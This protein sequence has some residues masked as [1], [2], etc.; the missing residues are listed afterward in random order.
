[1]E[2][3]V[4]LMLHDECSGFFYPS[5]IPNMNCCYL[6]SHRPSDDSDNEI[7]FLFPFPLFT[8]FQN[9]QHMFTK[10]LQILDSL[11]NKH[12]GSNKLTFIL[13]LDRRGFDCSSFMVLFMVSSGWHSLLMEQLVGPVS[14]NHICIPSTMKK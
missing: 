6:V 2:L 4:T 8:V 9:I 1:M 11:T 12:N 14:N 10:Q 7:L 13:S 3:L 5:E